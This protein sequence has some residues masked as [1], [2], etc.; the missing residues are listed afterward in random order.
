MGFALVERTVCEAKPFVKWAGGKRQ[1]L[2][3]FQEFY[4]QSLFAGRIKRYIEPFVGGG[5]VLFDLLQ[6]FSI[7]E[8]VI[9]DINGELI[10]AYKSVREHL[11]CLVSS[12]EDLEDEYLAQDLEGRKE[13]YYGIREVYNSKKTDSTSIDLERAVQFIFLNRTCFNGLY[14]VNKSGQFNVPFGN[15]EKPTICDSENLAVVSDLLKRV[16]ILQGDYRQ[17]ADYVDYKS[18]VYFDPP[19]RPLNVTSSFTSYNREDFNDDD[20][21]E[22][23]KFYRQLNDTGALLMLSNS[24]PHN[25]DPN[26]N[27]FDE[28][29]QGFNITRVEAKRKINSKA[30]GRG[31]V[32]EIL[33]T[34]Y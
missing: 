12:L 15:Y 28:L 9:F 8:A 34:N 16:E 3:T 27:F 18:F 20:Q 7:K 30:S 21:I 11:D 6:R 14:R 29:Y 4:P 31:A 23:A 26:D 13:I 25:V 1:L 17:A 19:Y 24:D 22:L 2:S 32:S 5:A 33:V 10:N